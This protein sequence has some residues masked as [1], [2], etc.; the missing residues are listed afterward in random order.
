[1]FV[2]PQMRPA[3][4]SDVY[5]A[6]DSINHRFRKS[7]CSGFRLVRKIPIDPDNFKHQWPIAAI[8]YNEQG[9]L[10]CV[11]CDHLPCFNSNVEVEY[12]LGNLII[13]GKISRSA[14]N[15]IRPFSFLDVNA[16]NKARSP[17]YIES[18]GTGCW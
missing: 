4:L 3:S 12:I 5:L 6:Y 11:L 16:A 10:F 1:M 7:Y 17:N 15:K 9:E 8:D 2:I 14:L 18:S 13:Q